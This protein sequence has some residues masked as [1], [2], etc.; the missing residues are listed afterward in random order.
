MKILMVL[1]RYFPPD[2]RVE[3]EALSLIRNGHEVHIACFSK[4]GEER[5]KLYKKI[6]LH[7]K[8]ISLFIY[9]SSVGA[10]KF[11]FYFNFWRSFLRKLL[12]EGKYDVIHLHDLPI[13]KVI[14]E[15]QSKRKI[16]FILD[17]HENYPASLEIA[18]HTNTLTG[19]LLSSNKQ[20]RRYEIKYAKKADQIITVV[21]E[22]KNRIASY[23]IDKNK[24]TVVENTSNLEEF[25]IPPGTPD[26][27]FIT[28]YYAGNLNIHRGLQIVIRGLSIL[29][30]EIKN[31]RLWIVGDGS[32]KENLERLIR[33][34]DLSEHVTFWGWK[35]ATDLAALLAQSDYALIPHLKSEQTDNSSPNKLYQYS[36]AGKPIICSNCRSLERYINKVKCGVIYTHDSPEDFAEKTLDLIHH[37]KK[38]E[39]GRNGYKAVVDEYNWEQTEKSLI[40]MYQSLNL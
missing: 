17:L 39:M 20:W 30:K 10:L 35:N 3:K 7:K 37:P 18:V 23:G 36:Y 16:K 26:N 29:R 34:Y 11:P 2:D 6:V 33:E 4:S 21:D 32:Y 28:L 31:I 9:K 40:R 8:T 22:M 19:K 38:S 24:I 1:E 13:A 27:N 12:E 14:H 25:K 15:I 5:E